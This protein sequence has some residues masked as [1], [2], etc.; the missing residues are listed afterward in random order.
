MHQPQPKTCDQD[1]WKNPG[2]IKSRC[3]NRGAARGILSNMVTETGATAVIKSLI[4]RLFRKKPGHQRVNVSGR[5]RLDIA[6]RLERYG[7]A[8]ALAQAGL[9]DVAQE[10][11]RHEIQERPKILV[12]GREDGFSRPLVEYAVGLAKRMKYEIVAL[13]CANI[14][15]EVLE[16]RSPYL[17]ELLKEFNSRAENAVELLASRAAEEGVPLRHVVKSGALSS[18]IRELEKQV[19]RLSFVLTESESTQKGGLETSI[20][21]FCINK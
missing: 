13:N 17:E 14:A 20:P 19:S 6:R 15:T 8:A 2:Q 1:G 18:C 7:E 10:I 16:K 5:K 4:D 21:V 11:I 9:Q 3:D 12:V